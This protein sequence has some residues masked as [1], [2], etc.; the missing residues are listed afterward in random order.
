RSCAS[1]SR[2]RAVLALGAGA[3]PGLGAEALASA[4]GS[5]TGEPAHVEAVRRTLAA[6]GLGEDALR[7]PADL[8]MRPEARAAA[9]E[10]RRVYHNCSGK[11]AWMLA[12]TV[13]AGWPAEGYLDPAHPLQEAISRALALWP[14]G[15]AG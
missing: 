4:C 3:L 7:C 2:A 11:H 5:H 15:E 10:P 12:G 1:P 13:A 6:I 14:E 9:G 8:P